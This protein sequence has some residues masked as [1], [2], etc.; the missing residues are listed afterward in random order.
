MLEF[1]ILMFPSLVDGFPLEMHHRILFY[2]IWD[3]MILGLNYVFLTHSLI[4]IFY[5]YLLF[6]KFKI[7]ME[8]SLKKN[9]YFDII[10][11]T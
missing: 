5:T 4:H 6:F 1:Y 3:R 10:S 7:D 9:D 11:Y 2:M 8:K